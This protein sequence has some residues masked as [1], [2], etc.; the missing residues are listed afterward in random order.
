MKKTVFI[1]GA[2]SGIGKATAERFAN[3][4]YGLVLCGRRQER[5]AALDAVIAKWRQVQRAEFPIG[6]QF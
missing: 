6:Q 4:G 2:S 1:T 3:E 5:L